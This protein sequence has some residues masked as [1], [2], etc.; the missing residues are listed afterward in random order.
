MQ[1]DFLFFFFCDLTKKYY[2]LTLCIACLG[3]TG[4]VLFDYYLLL[5]GSRYDVSLLNKQLAGIEENYDADVMLK[6]YSSSYWYFA[7]KSL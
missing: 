3:S 6:K 7:S 4:G 1:L 5:Y 2:Y